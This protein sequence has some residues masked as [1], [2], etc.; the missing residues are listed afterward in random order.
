MLNKNLHLLKIV[1]FDLL[2]IEF[3]PAAVFFLT[4]YLTGENF[5]TAALSLGM[6]TIAVLIISKVV[7]QRV[8]WFALFSGS[9]TI[10]TA[11]VTYWFAAPWVL[12]VKDTV[13]YFL[14]ALLLGLSMWSKGLIFKTFFGHIFAIKDTG[15]M[16]L[17]RRWLY[18][19]VLA[20]LSNELVRMYLSVSD[21]VLYKQFILVFF[22]V[23]GF[24]Q[25]T[26]TIRHR[27]PTADRFGLRL[28][29]A[30]ETD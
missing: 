17:E 9:I 5:P 27:L 23:Y 22:V 18:F 20:A 8:P 19:F 28:Q 13:Y 3:G 6:A 29:A 11:F 14:F 7:N 24:Y 4:F 25:F 16:L 26:V 15:W 30:P 21:W 10:A 2:L 1:F 12:I